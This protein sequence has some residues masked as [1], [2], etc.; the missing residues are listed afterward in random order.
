MYA[1]YFLADIEN[2]VNI[3]YH[4]QGSFKSARVVI[5]V[6]RL[7]STIIRQCQHKVHSAC[8]L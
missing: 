2:K 4:P 5:E 6:P 8:C 3:F 7:H 1:V